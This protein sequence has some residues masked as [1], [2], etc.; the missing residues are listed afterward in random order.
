MNHYLLAVQ[1]V[2]GESAD[3]DGAEVDAV[4][5]EM[6]ASG[7]W[8]FAA[9]LRPRHTASV[10]RSRENE[11]LITD[12]P[13]AESKEYLAGFWVIQA[14]DLATAHTWASKA[15]QACRRP[16]EVTPLDTDTP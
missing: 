8:L 1:M 14:P 10:V 4:N 13:F 11:I 16:I 6:K 2:E 5:A 7:A 9:G 15:T 12:G 3:H